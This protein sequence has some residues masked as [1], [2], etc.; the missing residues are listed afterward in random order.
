M[1]IKGKVLYYDKK[2]QKGII[3]E[4][5]GF[6]YVVSSNNLVDLNYLDAGDLVEFEKQETNGKLYAVNVTCEEALQEECEHEFDMSEGG[7]CLN[8]GAEDYYNYIDED[9]GQER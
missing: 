2:E 9:Y 4:N 7:M 8:C 5:D 1:K 6:Q 3:Q